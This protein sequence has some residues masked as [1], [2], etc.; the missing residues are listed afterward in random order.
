MIIYAKKNLKDIGRKYDV[1]EIV[2]YHGGIWRGDG[3]RLL[4]DMENQ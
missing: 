3:S 4:Q 2:C 1:R